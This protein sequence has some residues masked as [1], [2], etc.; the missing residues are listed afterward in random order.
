MMMVAVVVRSMGGVGGRAPEGII[1]WEVAG[2]CKNGWV[3]VFYEIWWG[4]L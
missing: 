2:G 4:F 1:G 3:G